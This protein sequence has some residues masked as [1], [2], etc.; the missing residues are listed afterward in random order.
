[1]GVQAA[2]AIARVLDKP[3]RFMAREHAGDGHVE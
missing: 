1:M 3:V 2:I